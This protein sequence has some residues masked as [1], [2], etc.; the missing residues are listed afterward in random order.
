MP[1]R[2][3]NRGYR[4]RPMN[5]RRR[6]VAR[7]QPSTWGQTF[8]TASKALSMAYGIKKLINTEFKYI[9]VDTG[10]NPLNTTPLVTLLNGIPNGTGV[11]QR[12]GRSVKMHKLHITL[13]LIQNPAN[14][15]SRTRF[16]ILLDKMT[17]GMNPSFTEMYSGGLSVI[18]M[19]NPDFGKRFHVLMDKNI[20]LSSNG[21]Q[22]STIRQYHLDL[23]QL[24]VEF[25]GTTGTLLS[26]S[27][28]PIF[29]IALSDSSSQGPDYDLVTRIRY[30][31]N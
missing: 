23:K 10:L 28:N 8:S 20:E 19:R 31:D 13:R 9:D 2:R 18:S 22:G 26:I 29:A 5:R 1:Y 7:R 12:I 16:I 3:Y 21:G 17:D 30:V 11:S 14:G 25:A 15:N 6:P 24:H 27:A 4:N